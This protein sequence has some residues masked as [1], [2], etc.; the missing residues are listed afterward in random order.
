MLFLG[1]RLPARTDAFGEPLT[2]AQQDRALWDRAPI[3]EAFHHFARSIGGAELSWLHVEAAIASV[4][5]AAPTYADTDW[6]KILA[7]YDRLLT[8]RNT[9]IVRLNRAVAVAKVHGPAPALAELDSIAE[10]TALEAYLLLPATRAQLHWTLG[11]R[12]AA[13]A[14]LKI[15]LGLPCSQPEQLFLQRRLAACEAGESAPAF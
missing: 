15:A 4:H 3:G 11:D 10:D 14:Q 8:L 12:G 7:H 9:P 5:A 2:L 13:A 6:P 1:A